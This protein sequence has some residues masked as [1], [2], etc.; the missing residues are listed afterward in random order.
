[1]DIYYALTNADELTDLAVEAGRAAHML[2]NYTQGYVNLN[3]PE[4]A[5]CDNLCGQIEGQIRILTAHLREKKEVKQILSLIGKTSV[6]LGKILEPGFL[7][8][9]KVNQERLEMMKYLLRIVK[10]CTMKIDRDI[11]L[12]LL[13]SS[14]SDFGCTGDEA[15]LKGLQVGYDRSEFV[16]AKFDPMNALPSYSGKA[17]PS[18]ECKQEALFSLGSHMSNKAHEIQDAVSCYLLSHK[19]TSNAI[20][21]LAGQVENDARAVISI[22]TVH[23]N[24]PKDPV[25]KHFS[26]ISGSLEQIRNSASSDS[27]PIKEVRS[28]LEQCCQEQEAILNVARSV[29]M[30][31]VG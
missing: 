16:N 8:D 15:A 23:L 2:R 18:A 7:S 21:N 30:A 20:I 25:S 3:H 12:A 11:T 24:V 1:M 9:E 31:H 22:S 27:F 14:M 17:F 19:D 13:K 28:K 4:V 26:K 6:F 29:L 5:T 10:E